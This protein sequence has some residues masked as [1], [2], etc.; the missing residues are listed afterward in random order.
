MNLL[1]L[2]DRL[3]HLKPFREDE[4]PHE[5]L[6]RV[7]WKR[8]SARRFARGEAISFRQFSRL[9]YHS[10]QGIPADFLDSLDAHRRSNQ[11]S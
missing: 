6:G 8:G 10:M 11:G 7:I 3:Q 5:E 1:H 4:F 9:L 2:S